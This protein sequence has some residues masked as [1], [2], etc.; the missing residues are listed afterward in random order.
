MLSEA[1]SYVSRRLGF[2]GSFSFWERAR[3]AAKKRTASAI[4]LARREA[5]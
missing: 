3:P 5:L 1:C 2:V 4:V